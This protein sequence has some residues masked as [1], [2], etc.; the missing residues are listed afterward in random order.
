MPVGDEIRLGLS[1]LPALRR[2]AGAHIQ[3]VFAAADDQAGHRR[4]DRDAEA[5]HRPPRRYRRADFCRC[6]R[7]VRQRFAGQIDAFVAERA[8]G[9][10]G[11]FGDDADLVAAGAAAPREA[12]P[13]AAE[14]E[15]LVLPDG[16]SERLQQTL[17]RADEADRR[18]VAVA[19][20]GDAGEQRCFCHK[21]SLLFIV[22]F[23]SPRV[24]KSL[25]SNPYGVPDKSALL[26]SLR[27]SRRVVKNAA[28]RGDAPTAL[29]AAIRACGHS[30]RAPFR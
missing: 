23:F 6:R 30:L 25:P 13:N 19:Q 14:G 1:G 20:R 8:E 4:A 15:Q 7:L 12:Q 26:R 3:P 5:D 22:R 28:R 24:G 18:R 2:L 11:D 10:R 21:K 9:T 29:R 27:K 16:F 17:H